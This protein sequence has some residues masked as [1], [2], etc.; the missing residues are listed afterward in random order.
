MNPS[1]RATKLNR[2]SG[3]LV[4]LAASTWLCTLIGMPSNDLAPAVAYGSGIAASYWLVLGLGVTSMM[5]DIGGDGSG[6][7]SGIPKFYLVIK[8]A[9]VCTLIALGISVF[10]Y[11]IM[12][13]VGGFSA[14]F[15]VMIATTVVLF[16]LDKAGKL[17][18]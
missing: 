10:E 18:G 12:A 7:S 8:F 5:A 14:V 4:L 3:S 16:Y 15:A 1:K 11:E 9:A 6:A 17:H 13:V 2:F